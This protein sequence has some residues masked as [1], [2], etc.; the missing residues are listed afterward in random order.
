M[1]N[2]LFTVNS[3]LPVFIVIGI[4]I[5]L[6]RIKLV[7]DSFIKTSSN[8]VFKVSIPALLFSK[9]YNI[10]VSSIFSGNGII[11]LTAGT[12]CVFILCWIIT[13]YMKD[14][15]ESRGVFIQ[16]VYRS[17]IAIIAYAIILNVFGEPGFIKAA[18]FSAFLMP[19]YNILAVVALTVFINQNEKNI[20]KELLIKIATNP[21]ILSVSA[22]MIFSGFKI[23]LH[24]VALN[25]IS[26]LA[27][28]TLPLA[29]IGIGASLNFDSISKNAFDSVF[30]SAL[31]IIIVPACITYISYLSGMRGDSLG[32]IFIITGAPTA[33]ASFIMAKAMNNNSELAANIV[34]ITT[35]VSVV[36]ISAGIFILKTFSLI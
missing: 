8:V 13:I 27:Q 7:D 36:T 10:D 12:L 9:L 24:P 29:L 3:V 30:A 20:L 28:M 32:V 33:V 18:L 23:G 34:L 4:G 25:S 35:L 19:V 26:T 2:L 31:K 21:V 16:G 6:K 11:I 17:N 15:P 5:V 14:K 22:A 1:E